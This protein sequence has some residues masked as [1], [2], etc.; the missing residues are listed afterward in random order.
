VIEAV[1]DR[2]ARR[3]AEQWPGAEISTRDPSPESNPLLDYFQA[4]ADGPG[5]WKWEH[6]FGASEFM[7]G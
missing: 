5:I 2:R 3:F 1:T 4:R 7:V 6:Y